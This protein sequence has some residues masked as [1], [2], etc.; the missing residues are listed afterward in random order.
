MEL[1]T[2]LLF[3]DYIELFLFIV[4]IKY[5]LIYCRSLHSFH[6]CYSL[7]HMHSTSVPASLRTWFV[8]HFVADA[9]FGLPLFIAPVASL[10][11]F[12][13]TM[14]DPV[15]TRLVASAFIAI[16]TTSLLTRTTDASSFRSLLILKLIWSAVALFGLLLNVL[17]GAPA[18]TWAAVGIFVVFFIVWAYYYQRLGS[19]TADSSRA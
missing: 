2:F 8:I 7:T 10:K 3:F 11:M 19:H 14:I 6:L 9:L 18:F 17:N 12:G 1:S 4:L 16:G 13:W 15:A 5:L